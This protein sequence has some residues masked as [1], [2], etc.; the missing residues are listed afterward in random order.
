M[1][2]TIFETKSW[3]DG[4]SLV[5][6]LWLIASP[7]VLGFSDTTLVFWN[8]FAFGVLIAAM[9]LVVLVEF[10]E[11]EEWTGIA[12]GAGLAVSPWVLG[13]TAMTGT[14]AAI[15]NFVIVG[16][17]TL[18]MSAWSLADHRSHMQT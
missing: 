2:D 6:G 4:L 13:V 15:W 11:W 14:G 1:K 9:A 5:L 3:Q 17:L 16:L 8:A 10:H 12:I 7:W 18:A